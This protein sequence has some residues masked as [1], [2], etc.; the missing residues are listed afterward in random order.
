MPRRTHEAAEDDAATEK[1]SDCLGGE[2]AS[3]DVVDDI[4]GQSMRTGCL[5][6]LLPVQWVSVLDRQVS[7]GL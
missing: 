6:I 4:D 1:D 7:L 3:S 2:G 5:D